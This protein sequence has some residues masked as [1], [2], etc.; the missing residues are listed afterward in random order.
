MGR[1]DLLAGTL[2]LMPLVLI[3]ANDVAGFSLTALIEYEGEDDLGFGKL[4]GRNL[5]IGLI[6]AATCAVILLI[7]IAMAGGDGASQHIKQGIQIALVP[8]LVSVIL[9]ILFSA[10]LS[11]FAKKRY[12]KGNVPNGYALSVAAMF[13]ALAVQLIIAIVML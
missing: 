13:F 12:E 4:M 5:A 8:A 7:M 2:I 6:A 3:I 11:M 1:L 10:L 9:A